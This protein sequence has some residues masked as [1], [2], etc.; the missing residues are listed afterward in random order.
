[1]W[2][3]WR[4]RTRWVGTRRTRR[5]WSTQSASVRRS[6]DGSR[7][8]QGRQVEQR[9][10]HKNGG[11]N[12]PRPWRTRWTRSRWTPATPRPLAIEPAL[13]MKTRGRTIVLPADV[14]TARIDLPVQRGS[15]YAFRLA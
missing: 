5:L 4:W 3:S 15:F 8:R 14:I 9:R 2:W 11:T 12:G 10:A 7:R 1:Q 13:E 6:L